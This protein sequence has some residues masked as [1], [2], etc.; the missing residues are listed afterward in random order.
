MRGNAE[1]QARSGNI[2]SR[3]KSF[4]A[5]LMR[6]FLQEVKKMPKPAVRRTLD[7]NLSARIQGEIK[8]QRVSTKKACEYAG[9]SKPTL[10]KLYKNPTAYFPQTLKLM[11]CLSIPIA[12]VREMICDPW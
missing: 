7:Y 4:S 3:W 5:C 10:L 2:G 1:E 11:R 12:D 6:N 8:A 9:M